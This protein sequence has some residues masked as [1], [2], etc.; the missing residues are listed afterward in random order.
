MRRDSAIMCFLLATSLGAA[1]VQFTEYVGEIKTGNA[2]TTLAADPQGRLYYGTFNHT[3]AIF[4]HIRIIEDPLAAIGSPNEAGTTI[5]MMTGTGKINASGR[6]VQSMAIASDNTLFVGGD[7]SGSTYNN[8]WKFNYTPG[9]PPTF[10]E[11]TSF[12]EN[13]RTEKPGRRSGVS[14]VSENG[15]GLLITC[16]FG[17]TSFVDYFNFEGHVV[18][19]RI[20]DDL[21][22]RDIHFIP[23]FNVAYPFRNG[24]SNLAIIK[25]YISG[26]DPVT[27][28]GTLVPEALIPD[29]G[30]AN[31]TGHSIQGGFY[32]GAQNQ[33]F[34]VDAFTTEDPLPQVRVFNVIDNGTS[35][36]LAY[37]LDGT[38]PESPFP[39]I[40]DPVVI[41]N[42]L[43]I[44]GYDQFGTY[45][46]SKIYVFR[47]PTANV[48]RWNEY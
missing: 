48:R 46:S 47:D 19:S 44:C 37:A 3:G 24:G 11:D 25:S 45:D 29:G 39:R 32:Y 17:S 34:V 42:H 9:T 28:G 22:Y 36:S 43:F 23:Q 1:Q 7:N 5:T 27:G 10:T 35:L 8:V 41:D 20:T 15:N 30:I 26:I 21:Y 2:P 40:Y 18:G 14:I 12:T 6:G 38:S 31:T 13:V 33:L 4:S 16:G